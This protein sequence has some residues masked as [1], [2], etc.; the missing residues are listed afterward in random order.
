LHYVNGMLR[1]RCQVACSTKSNE[2][3]NEWLMF[4]RIMLLMLMFVLAALFCVGKSINKSSLLARQADLRIMTYNIRLNT[5]DDGDNQWPYRKNIAA[6]MIRFH[7]ADIA[8]LHEVL[9]DQIDDLTASLPEYQRSGVGRDDGKEAGEFKDKVTGRIFYLFNTH[10]DHKGEVARR[11]SA[12]LL[13]QR[14]QT[15][16]GKIPVIVTGDFNSSPESEL[17]RIIVSGLATD[18]ATKLIDSEQIAKFPHHGPDGTITRFISANLPSNQTIDYI[19]I[20]NNIS[21][22]RHGT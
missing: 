5:P 3:R 4:K 9:K 14:L 19:F 12:N 8:G 18:P 22:S 17:Y 11:E 7:R 6:S 1:M 13:L 20:K 21:V 16:A 2:S 15:I 10:F